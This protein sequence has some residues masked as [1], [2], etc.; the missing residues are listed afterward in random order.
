ML[1]SFP[2]VI[3]FSLRCA[4]FFVTS[5]RNNNITNQ[6]KISEIKPMMDSRMPLFSCSTHT[7][8]QVEHTRYYLINGRGVIHHA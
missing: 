4:I 8:D 5:Y 1:I 2:F 7:T 6:K 3:I